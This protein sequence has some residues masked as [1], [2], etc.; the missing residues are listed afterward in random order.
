M[1][2]GMCQ[3]DPG[4]WTLAA[5]GRAADLGGGDGERRRRGG[6]RTLVAMG[7]GGDER[8]ADLGGM[9]IPEFSP[10]NDTF[11]PGP[12][13]APVGISDPTFSSRSDLR[14]VP[15]LRTFLLYK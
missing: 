9:S 11:P 2:W 10:Q 3:A 5:T 7:S 8:E 12:H 14:Y 4:R 15:T 13:I 6:R 1:G